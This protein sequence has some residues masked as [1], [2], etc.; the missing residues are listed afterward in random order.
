MVIIKHKWPQNIIEVLDFHC[1]NK[2]IA[3]IP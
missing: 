1:V 2:A 3:K